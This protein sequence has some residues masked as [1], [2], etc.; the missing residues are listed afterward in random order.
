M[1]L[2]DSHCH[3]NRLHVTAA[4]AIAD[5]HA[6]GVTGMMCIGV[7]ADTMPEVLRI[8][9]NYQSVWASVGIHPLSVSD[10]FDHQQLL[11][12]L[13]HDKVVA[14]G[15]TGLD[16]HYQ[17]EAVQLAK[18]RESFEWH[19]QQSKVLQKPVVIHTR[20][21]EKDTLALINEY[22]CPRAGGILHCFTE[23]WEMAKAALD[24]G[25]HISISG[26]V[27]F[28]SASELREVTRKIPLDRLLIETDAPWLTPAP[29]RGKP[30][31]PGY[32]RDVG[33]YIAELRGISFEA[34]AEQTAENFTQLMKL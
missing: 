24:F 7:D 32:V 6:R 30:N 11:Q 19:L 31:L 25:Y 18:Q 29:N 12:W 4:E 26:I 27:T 10:G 21:A 22:G 34:L 28:G 9:E 23:R 15:E 8:A 14:I 16:Y 1:R 2:I 13:S 33:E 20:A 17:K 5:A 3:L